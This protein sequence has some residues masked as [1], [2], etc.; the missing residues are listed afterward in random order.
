MWNCIESVSM[1]CQIELLLTHK[2]TNIAYNF[3]R[4]TID[5]MR[6]TPFSFMSQDHSDSLYSKLIKG[7]ILLKKENWHAKTDEKLVLDR[8]KESIFLFRQSSILWNNIFLQTKTHWLVCFV[9]CCK[10][11]FSNRGERESQ[12]FPPCQLISFKKKHHR[13]EGK[14]T[15]S[16]GTQWLFS[17]DKHDI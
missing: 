1:F 12:F 16:N 5:L 6:F 8:K 11:F 4:V 2:D 7:A 3:I 10:Q 9:W 17:P 15:F 14:K 13:L